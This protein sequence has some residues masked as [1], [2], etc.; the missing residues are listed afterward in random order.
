M[1]NENPINF[2]MINLAHEITRVKR[3]QTYFG[4]PAVDLIN[5]L[6]DLAA[7]VWG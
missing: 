5:C 7:S 3:I 2:A 1:S 6:S 4:T